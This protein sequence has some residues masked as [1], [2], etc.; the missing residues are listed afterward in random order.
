MSAIKRSLPTSSRLFKLHPVVIDGIV[1]ING[2][3]TNCQWS[4]YFRQPIIM[5]RVRPVTNVLIEYYHKLEGHSG[6]NQTLSALRTKFWI[7]KGQETVQNVLTKCITCKKLTGKP[8]DQQMSTLR[9]H[10]GKPFSSVGTDY[11]GPLLVK[12]G[13]VMEKRYGCLLT[14]EYKGAAHSPSTESF[15]I[16]FTRFCS[17]RGAPKCLVTTDLIL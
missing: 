14:S 13:R 5:P 6:T 8:C 4:D 2:R 3:L 10:D 1:R 15:L 12:R 16:V 11:F 9:H 17:R 7:I